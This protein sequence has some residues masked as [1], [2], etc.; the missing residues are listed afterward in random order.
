MLDNYRCLKRPASDAKTMDI[1][2]IK[3]KITIQL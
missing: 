3:Q 2:D 1:T